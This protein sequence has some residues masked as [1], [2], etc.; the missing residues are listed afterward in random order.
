VDYFTYIVV[1]LLRSKPALLN[2]HFEHW[3]QITV[4][5]GRVVSVLTIGL[6]FRGFKPAEDDRFLRTI[7][8]VAQL[9]SEE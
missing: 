9:P 2:F 7:R 6:M 4:L 1:S 8:T 3:C 5:G